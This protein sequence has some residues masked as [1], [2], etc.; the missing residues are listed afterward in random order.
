MALALKV[1]RREQALLMQGSVPHAGLL[2]LVSRS[3]SCRCFRSGPSPLTPVRLVSQTCPAPC[4]EL[5][6]ARLLCCHQDRPGPRAR[7]EAHAA[8]AERH[9]E[10]AGRAQAP[11]PGEPWPPLGRTWGPSQPRLA[12][13]YLCLLG[14]A[15]P[16]PG[17]RSVLRIEALH[18]L[19]V[20]PIGLMGRSPVLPW[21][22]PCTSACQPTAPAQRRTHIH[23]P[24]PGATPGP[25]ARRRAHLRAAHAR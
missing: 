25:L 8:D 12:P 3:R 22:L 18:V 11:L 7:A 17:S 16:L 5:A 14:R 21:P 15:C 19:H 9:P 6:G 23:D 10:E 2:N 13:A 20:G 4:P 24:N 1:G